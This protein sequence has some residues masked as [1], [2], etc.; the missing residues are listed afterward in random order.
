MVNQW[1][2][3]AL[4]GLGK[5]IREIDSRSHMPKHIGDDV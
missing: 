5:L 3:A 2:A 1:E 4:R